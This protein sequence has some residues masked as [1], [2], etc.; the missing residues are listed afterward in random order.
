MHNI[1]TSQRDFLL[2]QLKKYI[3]AQVEPR[4]IP[5]VLKKPMGA[6]PKYPQIVLLKINNSNDTMTIDRR[7]VIDVLGFEID[8]FTTNLIIDKATVNNDVICE[9]LS[10]LADDVMF[11]YGYRRISQT[12]TP[13]VDTTL[14]RIVSRYN[15]RMFNNFNQIV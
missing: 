14:Y 3:T 15:G 7:Q 12:P 10:E 13:T 2:S 8:I 6:Q 1:N 5:N 4:Y 9:E 11:Y